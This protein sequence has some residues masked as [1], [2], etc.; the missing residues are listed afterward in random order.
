M[1]KFRIRSSSN[2]S[3]ALEAS[4]WSS[5]ISKIMGRMP[6]GGGTVN[7]GLDE[8]GATEVWTD[9][10]SERFVIDTDDGVGSAFEM[11]D[12]PTA[13]L[14]DAP[15]PGSGAQIARVPDD[16][17]QEVIDRQ[18]TDLVSKGSDAAACGQ[19]LN[20]LLTHIPAESGS[21]LLAEGSH[22]RFTAV[23]GPHSK[24]LEGTAIPIEK[25]IAGAVASSGRTILVKEAR[26]NPH[27]DASV[28]Q[29]VNHITRT[30]LAVPIGVKGTVI[31]VLELLNPFG[32]DTFDGWHQDLTKQVAGAL[33]GRFLA[34]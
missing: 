10:D 28:D 20:L 33:A 4:D 32:T 22:L 16:V 6:R 24:E 11:P 3:S 19:A 8:D 9:G 29:S 23:R 15:L 21:V 31:G 30:I 25:G 27:H 2:E 7:I 5:A 12:V 34:R 18:V 26:R 17:E 14:W 13:D 1:P